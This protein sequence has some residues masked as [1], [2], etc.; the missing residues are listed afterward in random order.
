MGGK[1]CK[2][3]GT[4]GEAEAAKAIRQAGLAGHA[5]GCFCWALGNL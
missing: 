5:M 3:K 1:A 4:E 2:R